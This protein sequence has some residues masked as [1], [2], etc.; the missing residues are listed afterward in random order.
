MKRVLRT[1]MIYHKHDAIN[2]HSMLTMKYSPQNNLFLNDKCASERA[3]MNPKHVFPPAWSVAPAIARVSDMSSTLLLGFFFFFF[4]IVVFISFHFLF[5]YIYFVV[6][7]I[8]VVEE[9]REG[10]HRFTFISFTLSVTQ[11]L[12]KDKKKKKI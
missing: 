10:R 7:V 5:F 8:V 12:R 9:P 4:V 2:S 1:A 3:C 6:V 11:S